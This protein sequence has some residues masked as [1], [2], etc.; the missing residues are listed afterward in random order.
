MGRGDNYLRATCHPWACLWFLLPLLIAYEVGV[1]YFGGQQAELC[2]TGAD[3]WIRRGLQEIGLPSLH[4][5]PLVILTIFLVWS[6]FR[7]ADRPHD[8]IGVWLGMAVESVAFALLLW[9][10][11]RLRS[12]L[13]DHFGIQLLQFGLDSQRLALAVNFFGAGVYEE[14]LFRLLLFPIL[15]RVITITEMPMPAALGLAMIL[16]GLV[17]S[18]AHHLGPYGEPYQ[19]E[20]FI[21]RTLAGIYFAMLYQFRGFGIAAGAHASYDVLVGVAMI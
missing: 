7:M 3:A 18:Y 20:V 4:W 21:F 14:F 1:I 8:L 2:R 13:L 6:W 12:S 5:P 16:S 15:L 10:G 9:A 17:F 19:Q 11:S